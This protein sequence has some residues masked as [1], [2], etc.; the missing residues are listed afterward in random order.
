MAEIHAGGEPTASH[1]LLPKSWPDFLRLPNYDEQVAHLEQWHANHPASLT[2]ERVLSGM[3]RLR[4]AGVDLG[5][6]RTVIVLTESFGHLSTPKEVL[7]QIVADSGRIA[8]SMA[9]SANALVGLSNTF[10]HLNDAS[11][12]FAKL[13][14]MYMHLAEKIEIVAVYVIAWRYPV[15]A[16]GLKS[17]VHPAVQRNEVE[18]FKETYQNLPLISA[19][20]K[21]QQILE[22]S[23]PRGREGAPFYMTMEFIESTII[24]A[25]RRNGMN[26]SEQAGYGTLDMIANGVD[27]FT[28][29]SM[30][31]L[32]VYPAVIFMENQVDHLFENRNAV[33]HAS[34]CVMFAQTM[35]AVKA[36]TDPEV[37]HRLLDM[38]DKLR[39][40]ATEPL[41]WGL[42][43]IL[44]SII[45]II[46]K[47]TGNGEFKRP[48]T[49]VANKGTA[50]Y[51]NLTTPD[52]THRSENP[53]YK[54]K[55]DKYAV[56]KDATAEVWTPF[57][58]TKA[59]YSGQP[60]PELQTW[61]KTAIKPT[62]RTDRF[63]K[64]IP[65]KA[66]DW[67]DCL[68]MCVEGQKHDMKHRPHSVDH[69]K[70]L[71]YEVQRLFNEACVTIQSDIAKFRA[72]HPE[73][74]GATVVPS[75]GI[76]SSNGGSKHAV[77]SNVGVEISILEKS[78]EFLDQDV[79]AGKQP[80][81][82]SS[83]A[84]KRA[85]SSSSSAARAPRPA[86][87]TSAASS[88]APKSH[89][90]TLIDL[91]DNDY[92]WGDIDQPQFRRLS[93]VHGARGDDD[94]DDLFDD[95]EIN[96]KDKKRKS[97]YSPS[98]SSKTEV[99]K[100]KV[101]PRK[102]S[103]PTRQNTLKVTKDQ[104]VLTTIP[105]R[106]GKPVSA[107]EPK[108]NPVHTRTQRLFGEPVSS[109][110][111]SWKSSYPNDDDD[112]HT[113]DEEF[114]SSFANSRP[115]KKK[116]PFSSSASAESDRPRENKPVAS[117]EFDFRARDRHLEGLDLVDQDNPLGSDIFKDSNAPP[118]KRLKKLGDSTAAS[119]SNASFSFDFVND[120]NDGDDDFA[121]TFFL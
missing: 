65:N 56:R 115:K 15:H 45:R 93:G 32:F 74:D 48:I 8:N 41:N 80:R 77:F 64:K 5:P 50:E 89:S 2:I 94:D 72:E 71:R 112:D 101:D 88:A 104:R 117:S 110:Q 119:S 14:A 11:E 92:D 100:P 26:V 114:R 118:R 82:R 95:P 99:K 85:S 116:R 63:G 75:R 90:N 10:A 79:F 43:L 18:R 107:H 16:G 53:T 1:A 42:S 29:P 24:P 20:L 66:D 109:S 23:F 81:K 9:G 3:I 62:T 76:S 67:C 46:D 106:N 102:H 6:E 36:T 27:I 49:F 57:L 51:I 98:D 87:S 70:D 96:Y 7:D 59:A 78:C 108:P 97:T 37:Q 47:M 69:E 35:A 33:D 111:S 61:L 120:D 30:I 25:S 91:V 60:Y 4:S 73:L 105:S 40:K 28:D 38:F 103:V 39:D 44:A 22:P 17:F 52:Y 31:P 21:S 19:Y 83:T 12:L 34:N 86:K 121:D 54:E 113:T 58:E 55:T 84:A 13:K 68:G